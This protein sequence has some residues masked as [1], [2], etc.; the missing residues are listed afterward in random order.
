MREDETPAGSRHDHTASRLPDSSYGFFSLS[1]VDWNP[2]FAA[3]PQL[4]SAAF[5][6]S[7][8]I[9]FL[10]FGTQPTDLGGRAV[11]VLSSCVG[12]LNAASMALLGGESRIQASPDRDSSVT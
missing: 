12:L 6:P 2:P 1:F 11:G 4:L 9:V 3:A 7:G 5:D 10:S 8:S